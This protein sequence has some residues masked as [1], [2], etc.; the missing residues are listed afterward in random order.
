MLI[1]PT[2]SLTTYIDQFCMIPIRAREVNTSIH[3][4]ILLLSNADK[5][6]LGTDGRRTFGLSCYRLGSTS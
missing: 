3:G 1:V 2:L 6:L 4:E 5:P